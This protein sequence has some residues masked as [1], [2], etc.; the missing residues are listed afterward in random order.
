M[1]VLLGI[2]LDHMGRIGRY[3]LLVWFLVP[4]C[5]I[6]VTVSLFSSGHGVT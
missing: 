3:H 4:F 1:Y 2:L 5:T 6:N